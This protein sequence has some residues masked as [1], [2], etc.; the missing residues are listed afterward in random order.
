VDGREAA[1]TK[2]ENNA[3]FGKV[4]IIILPVA[5]PFDENDGCKAAGSRAEPGPRRLSLF[6]ILITVRD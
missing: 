3:V 5:K 1:S 2:R 6:N 4:N